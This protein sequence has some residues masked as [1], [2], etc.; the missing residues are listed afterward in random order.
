MHEA[1]T[2]IQD[3]F[4]NAINGESF[5]WTISCDRFYVG[6]SMA[7]MTN[8]GGRTIMIESRPQMDGSV[9]WVTKM[10]EWVLG[11]D[12]KYY[13]EPTPSSR[14]D[15]FIANTRFNTKEEALA[16]L[17]IHEKENLGNVM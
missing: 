11:K 13:Y 10:E 8:I 3:N 15:E 12:G 4:K 2:Y 1:P 5:N 6:N 9:K 7:Y 17:V 16:S 14:T